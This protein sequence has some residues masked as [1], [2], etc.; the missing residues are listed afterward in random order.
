M[1]QS[2]RE[3]VYRAAM[4]R[5]DEIRRRIERSVIYEAVIDRI[6]RREK[7]KKLKQ[8]HEA[9]LLKSLLQL[10]TGYYIDLCAILFIRKLEDGTIAVGANKVLTDEIEWEEVFEDYDEAVSLFLSK[11]EE[12]QL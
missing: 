1:G 12:L 8:E 9:I 2:R 5:S 11:K 7:A 10:S 6:S 3:K 4:K